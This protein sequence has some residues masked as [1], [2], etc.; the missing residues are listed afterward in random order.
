MLRTK[1]LLDFLRFSDLR[2][3][4]CVSLT[5]LSDCDQVALLCAKEKPEKLV[6]AKLLSKCSAK[7]PYG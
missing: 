2:V 5:L 1:E 3:K 4:V 6:L 7:S